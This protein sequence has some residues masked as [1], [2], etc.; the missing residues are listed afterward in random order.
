MRLLSTKEAL[1]AIDEARANKDWKEADHLKAILNCDY[2]YKVSIGS[3]GR[4][5]LV[6][7]PAFVELM[8]CNMDAV[9]S[10]NEDRKKEFEKV[11]LPG[12]AWETVWD[13]AQKCGGRLHPIIE[14]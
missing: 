5:T 12:N 2:S 13:N 4:A 6:Q 9:R 10:F 8:M 14:S 3:D 1:S 11:G 7:N